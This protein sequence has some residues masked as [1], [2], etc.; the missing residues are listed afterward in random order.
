[1]QY[2][3]SPRLKMASLILIVVG[4]LVYG[5]GL[6]L[7]FQDKA[8]PNYITDLIQAN[9]Q[10]FYGEFQS[11]EFQ[12]FNPKEDGVVNSY[13]KKIYEHQVANRP[14]AAF[15]VP[16]Y[17]AL[18][19]AGAALFFLSIQF[20]ANAGWSMVVTRVMEGIATYI[21]VG[22]VIVLIIMV[23][24]ALHGNHLYHW[25]DT[26]LIDVNGDHY[27]KYIATKSKIWL[28]VPGW[29][30]RSFIYVI[31]W[32]VFMVWIKRTTKKLDDTNGDLKV[33][34]QLYTRSVLF[35]I[36]F[37]LT[38]PAMAWDWIMSLDP[39]WYSTLFMW[40]GMVSYLV[41][42]VAAMA[43]ISI[44][45]K[46]KG[47]LPLFN[48]NHQHDLAKFM[49]GFSLLWTYLWFA[50]YML[51]WY[52]NIPEEVQY[53]QQRI[54][55]YKGY[56]WMLAVNFVAVLLIMIS[57]S[58]KRRSTLVFVMGFVIILG[59]YWDFYNQIMPA[60]V[61]AFHN[62]GFLEIGALLFVA[63][64]FVYTVFEYGISRLNLEAKGHP[65]FHESKIYEYPF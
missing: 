22:G 30:A 45:L 20:A 49:F 65:Y 12:K 48:D 1:M 3:F 55:Q 2:K 59:H 14:W 16:S 53:F 13:Q 38:T 32:W 37:A 46:R 11:A 4:A 27:D 31:L 63:G 40:Y 15:L 58:I 52:A 23:G 19:M 64:T 44:Y 24:A 57:S 21:P 25:M 17:L 6:Y 5:I 61:G 28:N 29:I 60:A 7:N 26:S 8:N 39:H 42:S 9:P 35:I 41:S 51:Q 50:Q 18:G 36:V 47:S 56:F 10:E 34:S 33:Y 43:I 54:V 62:F